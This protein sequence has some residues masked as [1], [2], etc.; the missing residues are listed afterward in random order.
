MIRETWEAVRVH[1]GHRMRRRELILSVTAMFPLPGLVR[2]QSASMPVVGFLNSASPEAWANNLAGFRQGLKGTGFVEGLNLAIDFRWAEGDYGRL[3]A[4][5]DD[6]A[7]R[8]VAVIFTAGGPVPALAAKAATSTIPIV[9]V[10][11][12][13]P[14]ERGLVASFAQ[15]GG[16]ITGVNFMGTQLNAKRLGLLHDLVPKIKRVAVLLNQKSQPS[17]GPQTQDIGA[18][19]AALGRQ[20][21]IVEAASE[22]ELDAALTKSQLGDA[23]ALLAAADPFFE[24]QRDRIVTRVSLL[25]LPAICEDREFADAGGLMSYGPDLADSYRQAGVYVGRVLKGEKPGDLPLSMPR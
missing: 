23:D 11:G 5:A 2:A 6:L 20:T 22:R 8:R 9:F 4:F 21:Q 7:A 3:A 14:V 12:G 25:S 16:D 15:P 24:I 13:D 10:M 18:A 17:L 1:R 19:A